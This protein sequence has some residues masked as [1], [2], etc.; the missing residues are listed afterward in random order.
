MRHLDDERAL[1]EIAHLWCVGRLARGAAH[2][3]NNAL[4]AVTGLLDGRPD[5]EA[6]DTE[7]D[8]CIRV[9][10]VLTRQVPERFDRVSECEL[11]GLARGVGAVL[12]SGLSRRYELAVELPDDFLYLECDPARIE[13]LLLVLAF[14]LADRSQRGGRFAL[15]A[16]RGDKPDTARVE[17]ELAASDVVDDSA[18]AIL[19]PASGEALGAAS[20]LEA[21]HR[22]AQACAGSVAAHLRPD[23][24]V[25]RV[26]LPLV[27]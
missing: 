10:R 4:T 7:L 13:L 18:A 26:L 19:E 15:R 22:I 3:L 2:S 20:A 23:G 16:E 27:E 24:L 5:D 21:A 17:F 1:L 8:R 14:R 12:E 11:V 6:L 25:I 9:A